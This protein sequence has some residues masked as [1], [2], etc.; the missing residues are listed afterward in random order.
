M[1]FSKDNSTAARI[2]D[3]KIDK[4]KIEKEKTSHHC[5]ICASGARKR[6]KTPTTLLCQWR[7]P[8]NT[9]TFE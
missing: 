4:E 1:L 7:A 5:A 8:I 2:V 9:K 3:T 6:T